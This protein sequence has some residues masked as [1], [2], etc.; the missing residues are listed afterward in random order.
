MSQSTYTLGYVDHYGKR[1]SVSFLLPQITA[2]NHDATVNVNI[3]A[4]MDAVNA[5]SEGNLITRTLTHSVVTSPL[6]LPAAVTA[7]KGNAVQFHFSYDDGDGDSTPG[8][9]TVPI[10]DLAAF[11]FPTGQTVVQRADFNAAEEALATA[12]EDYCESQ[13]GTAITVN[14]IVLIN[15]S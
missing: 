11:S 15:R 12:M 2:A 14:R 10:A 6:E 1:S 9:W 7:K 13:D 3:D 8:Y 5:L 4:I